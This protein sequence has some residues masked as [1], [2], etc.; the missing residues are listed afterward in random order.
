[1]SHRP[2]PSGRAVHE[3]VDG[4]D[5]GGQHGPWFVLVRHTHRPKRRSGHTP[6]VQAGS[7]KPDTGAE[8]VKPDTGS[9]GRVTPRGWVLVSGIKKWSLVGFSAHPHSTGDLLI[10]LHVCCCQMNR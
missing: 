4:W 10:A 6:F 3:D 9:F 5:I 7:E 2:E 8:A 1:L